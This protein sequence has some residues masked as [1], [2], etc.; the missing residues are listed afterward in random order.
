MEKIV[1]KGI[2]VD[3]HIHSRYSVTKDDM[4]ILKNSTEENLPM[5]I[6]KLKVNG[7][8]MCAITDH[9][10]FNYNLYQKLKTYEND[11]TSSL[12][13]V[14]PGVEF[15]VMFKRDG[16]EKQ[17]HVIALF[18]DENNEKLKNIESVLNV[19]NNHPDYD[20]QGCFSEQKFIQILAEIGLDT[21]LIFPPLQSL[22]RMMRIRWGNVHLICL[23]NQN[24]LKHLSLKIE[25]MNCLIIY[26]VK[27]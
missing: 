26:L 9:D 3:F 8:E 1:R 7:V 24:I 14:L 6:E 19:Q 25:K 10:T 27:S 18:S 13:K 15:S 17:L 2:K 23:L 21:V 12:V 11:I 5:L 16:N 4:N 20:K 22:R